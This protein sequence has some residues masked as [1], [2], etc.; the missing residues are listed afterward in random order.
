MRV[1]ITGAAGFVGRH[2]TEHLRAGGH[3]VIGLDRA[4]LDLCDGAATHAAVQEAEPDWI[5]HLAAEASVARSWEDPKAT[6]RNNLQATLSVLDAAGG[7]RVLL[8]GSGEIY[9]PPRSLPVSEDHP[10]APQNP[11]ASSK[12][13]ADLVAAFYAAD[14]VRT[15]SFNHFG[16]GQSDAYVVATFARQI[17]EAEQR[18]DEGVTVRTGELAARRDFTDVRDVVRAYTLLLERAEP[19]AYN[20]CSG[21]SRS[22]ADILA[23]LA[24]ESDVRVES[25]VDPA[26]VRANE[27]MEIRGSNDRL[28]EAT[29]WR[30]EI[31]FEQTVRDTLDWWRSR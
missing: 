4:A 10:F 24:S 22:A 19:G 11:Y 23:A 15:R 25:Q 28:T 1:L 21:V 5:A 9:G 12:A 2:L 29:G 7:A 30:P 6:I 17:A 18:G 20:V 13:A 8:V 3:E 27:V 14:V 16:P 26:R 31:P